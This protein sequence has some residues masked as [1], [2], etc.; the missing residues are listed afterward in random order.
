M[1]QVRASAVDRA[2]ESLP[3]AA[4]ITKPVDAGL[5]T[6]ISGGACAKA[7]ER[8]TCVCVDVY[9]K[10]KKLAKDFELSGSPSLPF[11]LNNT[12]GRH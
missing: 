5:A 10:N 7:R 6:A 3:V 9:A 12:S 2:R 11:V 4:Y 8:K 1:R